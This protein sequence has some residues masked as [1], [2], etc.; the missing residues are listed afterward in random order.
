MPKEKKP[1]TKNKIEDGYSI[2]IDE[3]IRNPARQEIPTIPFEEEYE[4][5]TNRTPELYGFD[6]NS[7]SDDFNNFDLPKTGAVI[8][9]ND[10][11]TL[12]FFAPKPDTSRK[13]VSSILN[14]KPTKEQDGGAGVEDTQNLPEIG[15]YVLMVKGKIILI[16][17]LYDVEETSKSIIYGDDV[18]YQ[19]I[20]ADDLMILKRVSLKI[21]IFIGE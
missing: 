12:P 1:H 8:D 16:G 14:Q 17:S 2:V 19:N 6:S 18:N 21:G 15:E 20:S 5:I 13:N 3:V 4:R 11:I 9:N 7:F 10:Y